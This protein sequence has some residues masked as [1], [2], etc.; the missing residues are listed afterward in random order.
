MPTRFRRRPPHWVSAA[1]ILAGLVAAARL[2]PR[3][4][5][6]QPPPRVDEGVYNVERVVDGDT[7]IVHIPKPGAPEG[8]VDRVRVR[9]LCID[10]P[11]SVKPNHPVEPFGPEAAEFAREFLKD[12][13]TTL[14]FGRR[15]VDQYDRLL[16][17]VFVGDVMLNEELARA[18]LA[19]VKVY[20][21]D[22]SPLTRRI[23]TAAEEAKSARRGVW[24]LE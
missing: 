6:G 20:A 13:R 2:L 9:L 7:I 15:R 23:E 1:V 3:K 16:A 8:E 22:E 19:R 14:R 4:R 12:K 11:E 5:P 10:T 24:S 21:G 18:G 17:F